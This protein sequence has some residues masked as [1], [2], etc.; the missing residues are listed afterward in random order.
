MQTIRASRSVFG[1]LRASGRLPMRREFRGPNKDGLPAACRTRCSADHNRGRNGRKAWDGRG[2]PRVALGDPG[3]GT[4]GRLTAAPVGGFS[5]QPLLAGP[6]WSVNAGFPYPEPQF[7]RSGGMSAPGVGDRLAG[8][9]ATSGSPSWRHGQPIEGESKESRRFPNTVP[10]RSHS[11]RA[12]PAGAPISEPGVVGNFGAKGDGG[13]GIALCVPPAS[14]CAR[15]RAP[16]SCGITSWQSSSCARAGGRKL[17]RFVTVGGRSSC[18]RAGGRLYSVRFDGGAEVFK[19]LFSR[20][21]PSTLFE[22]MAINVREISGSD[23][24]AVPGG[25]TKLPAQWGHTGPKQDR[26][27]CKGVAFAR[28]D[29]AVT[30][31]KRTIAN[32]N[33]APV[34]L[35]A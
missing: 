3:S 12:D 9:R 28:W 26:R 27:T 24:G 13:S 30:G 8:R 31:S 11:R 2:P 4:E 15:G 1:C 35:A 22:D 21:R 19:G 25:S 16:R 32:D 33:R 18:A 6:A 20:T 14:Y 10:R 23:P 29:S 17:D 5:A 7:I 34:A